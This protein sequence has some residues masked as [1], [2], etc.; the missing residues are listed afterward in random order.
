MIDP[1]ISASLVL[2]FSLSAVASLAHGQADVDGVSQPAILGSDARQQWFETSAAVQQLVQRSTVMLA[3][4][5]AIASTS[6]SGETRFRSRLRVQSGVCDDERF[7][8]EELVGSCSGTLID[9]HT[10]VTAG[11]CLDAAVRTGQRSC[12][13]TAVIFNFRMENE[14]ERAQVLT[15]RDVYYCHEVLAAFFDDRT[16]R[17][18]GDFA[19]FTIKRDR[20]GR[21]ATPVSLPHA[22]V[23]ILRGRPSAGTS[24]L[25]VGHPQGLPVKVSPGSLTLGSRINFFSNA[26][27]FGGNSGGGTFFVQGGRHVLAGVV[28]FAPFNCMNDPHRKGYCFD[29]R[30]GC[31]R[32]D[33]LPSGRNTHFWME[34]IV[35]AVCNPSNP[36]HVV[37]RPSHLCGTAPPVA[38]GPGVPGGG[39]SGGLGSA[40]ECSASGSGAPLGHLA[41]WL[42]V[43][44]LLVARRSTSRRVHSSSNTSSRGTRLVHAL[45]A[46]LALT[47]GCKSDAPAREDAGARHDAGDERLEAIAHQ[48]VASTILA[49][50]PRGP[51]GFDLD[52]DGVVDN[53]FASLVQALEDV[54]VDLQ[55]VIDETILQGDY[56]LLARFT[57]RRDVGALRLQLGRVEGA[58]DFTGFG[59]FEVRADVEPLSLQGTVGAGDQLPFSADADALPLRFPLGEGEVALPLQRVRVAG[60]L[61]EREGQTD[62]GG[63]LADED[64]TAILEPIAAAFSRRIAEAPGCPSACEEPLLQMLL[65][66]LDRDHDGQLSTAELRAHPLLAEALTPD[67]DADGDGVADHF[68][69]GVRIFWTRADFDVSATDRRTTSHRRE[70]NDPVAMCRQRSCSSATTCDACNGPTVTG[71][72]WCPTLGCV[73]LSRASECDESQWITV[74][75]SCVDCSGLGRDACDRNGFC[76]WSATCGRCIN[77]SRCSTIPTECTDLRRA[78]GC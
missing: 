39:G 19:V 71:C 38:P 76:G 14:D 13:G 30:A 43:A 28:A 51:V 10:V 33:V 11:H 27:L 34:P 49:R 65:D 8:C 74:R 64:V 62:L 35:E 1:R 2:A 56:L 67:V 53:A 77:D 50:S 40:A 58:P 47:L 26:D 25:T 59:V 37:T 12:D 3:P 46:T 63:L 4:A 36:H 66:A 41:F 61:P 21:T 57:A 17:Q 7:A 15:A 6:A 48:Y 70:K 29:S 60:E 45:V 72:G 20:R 16:S 18:A 54:G 69:F 44:L 42:G 23:P 75:S 5:S 9:G 52:G 73:S 78:R 22:P 55:D 24:I 68:S 32:E 31:F